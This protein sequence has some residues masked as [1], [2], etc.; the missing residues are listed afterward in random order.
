MTYRVT[1]NP[2][3]HTFAAEESALLLDAGLA[4]GIGLP[5]GC[6]SGVC[7]SCKA[8]VIAGEI[9]HGTA[10]EQ[11]LS[12]AERAQGITLLC[13]ASARSDLTLEIREAAGADDYPVKIMPARVSSMELAAPEVMILTL[14]LPASDKLRFRPGQYVHIL[15]RDGQKRSFSIA[16]APQVDD[17]LELH[18]RRVAGGQ[19]TDQV[20]SSMKPRDILRLEGPI[21]S[22]FLDE[23]SSAPIIFLAG[24]TGFAPIKSMVEHAINRGMDRPIHLYWGAGTPDGLYLDALARQW[25]A[26]RADF[27]YTPVIS[28]QPS[29]AWSGRTGLVHQAL[30]ADYADLSRHQVYA[31]GAPAMVDAARSDLLSQRALPAEAFFADAFTFSTAPAPGILP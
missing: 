20:F 19:F 3:G 4:Q 14:K 6:K 26:S 24:G 31:C 30:M 21:G 9:S 13:C 15:L 11:A 16:N 5:Y 1:L 8:K 29:A 22:F 28:G 12:T 27:R 23:G 2:S 25:A 7:G 17:S 10:S 18:V